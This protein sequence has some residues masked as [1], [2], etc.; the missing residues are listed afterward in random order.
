[1]STKPIPRTVMTPL[2][3]TRTTTPRFT[4]MALLSSCTCAEISP[5]TFSTTLYFSIVAFADFLLTL[6]VLY[7][8]RSLFLSA[9]A[10]PLLLNTRIRHCISSKSQI[11]FE[12]AMKNERG[13]VRGRSLLELIFVLS[14]YLLDRV[15]AAI[16]E[17]C[18]KKRA[19]HA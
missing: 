14:P 18:L 9:A 17:G 13:V 11:V 3:I 2:H 15:K 5:T 10:S 16:A 4:V 1:M 7:C 6:L 8:N 12:F 19:A